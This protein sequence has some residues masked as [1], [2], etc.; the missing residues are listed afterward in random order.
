MGLRSINYATFKLIKVIEEIADYLLEKK[1]DA[2]LI[3]KGLPFL[4]IEEWFTQEHFEIITQAK[5]IN[6]PQY[7]TTEVLINEL[8][9]QKYS[10]FNYPFKVKEKKT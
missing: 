1:M 7:E 5:Q 9:H 6:L 2:P 8:Q 3:N 10:Q 4:Y